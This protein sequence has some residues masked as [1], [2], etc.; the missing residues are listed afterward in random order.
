MF[1]VIRD[2][3]DLFECTPCKA[4]R[5]DDEN[6]HRKVRLDLANRVELTRRVYDSGSGVAL[7]A[8]TQP[9]E[10]A[11]S[12]LC[13]ANDVGAKRARSRTPFCLHEHRASFDIVDP[14][15][16]DAFVSAAADVRVLQCIFVI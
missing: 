13:L 11:I 5:C 9:N 12:R 8:V 7:L 10:P 15:S 14:E 16:I 4:A 3:I 6:M 2:A 1:E